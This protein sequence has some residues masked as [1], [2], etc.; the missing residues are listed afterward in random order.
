M[1]KEGHEL[2]EWLLEAEYGFQ[3]IANKK[4]RTS[5]LYTQR[6]EFHQYFKRAGEIFSP[7]TYRKE[8]SPI[9]TLTLDQ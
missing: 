3:F 6:T 2:A 9:S 5:V 8:Q 7:T 4:M 1:K